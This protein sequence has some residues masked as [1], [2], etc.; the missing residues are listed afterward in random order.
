MFGKKREADSSSSAMTTSD[1]LTLSDIDDICESWVSFY[2][3]LFAA[4]SVDLDVQADLF[5]H[6]PLSLLSDES[7]TCMCCLL[8]YMLH[9]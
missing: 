5:Y 1:G 6:L 2:S 9:L 3:D 4:S 7:P 8:R